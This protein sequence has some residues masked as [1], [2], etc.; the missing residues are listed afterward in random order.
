MKLVTSIFVVAVSLTAMIPV[1]QAE[2]SL[3]PYDFAR[4]LLRTEE[5]HAQEITKNRASLEETANSNKG[6]K[7]HLAFLLL[8]DSQHHSG[9]HE[10]KDKAAHGKGSHKEHSLEGD[11]IPSKPV[12][13]PQKYGGH[14][15]HAQHRMKNHHN[16]AQRQSGSRALQDFEETVNEG[17]P[18]NQRGQKMVRINL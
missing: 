12:I 11:A 8:D 17:F 3:I 18:R 10:R 7:H 16:D 14:S 15:R 5:N 13:V 6:K 1:E 2:G 9:D 4:K